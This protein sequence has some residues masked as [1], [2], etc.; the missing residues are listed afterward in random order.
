M[1]KSRYSV[2]RGVMFPAT[3]EPR[4]CK[5][6]TAG[7]RSFGTAEVAGEAITASKYGM[8]VPHVWSKNGG[9][10]TKMNPRSNPSYGVP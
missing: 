2:L 1:A 3:D 5:T 4:L 8:E 6:T 10:S 7:K 9:H